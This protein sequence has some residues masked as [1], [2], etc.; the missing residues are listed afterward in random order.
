MSRR[1]WSIAAVAGTVL[2]VSV[3]ASTPGARE[4]GGTGPSTSP[5]EV[6]V[7]AALTREIATECVTSTE[8]T[9]LVRRISRAKMGSPWRARVA[10][11][12]GAGCIETFV[13][14]LDRHVV[15]GRIDSDFVEVVVA[16]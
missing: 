6:S 5:A 2:V 12:V 10:R 15:T 7:L 1:A 13:T 16:D 8:W 14:D 4:V 9:R 3:G 11:G